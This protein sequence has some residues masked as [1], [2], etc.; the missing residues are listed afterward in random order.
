ME[1]ITLWFSFLLLFSTAIGAQTSGPI[2]P[3]NTGNAFPH[4]HS[5]SFGIARSLS[6]GDAHSLSSGGTSLRLE[7][8]VLLPLTLKNNVALLIPLGCWVGLEHPVLESYSSIASVLPE[9]GIRLRHEVSKWFALGTGI[10]LGAQVFQL[11]RYINSDY[12]AVAAVDTNMR[13]EAEIVFCNVP[14]RPTRPT[15]GISITPSYGVY[16]EQ[17][18]VGQ[19]F[20]LSILSRFS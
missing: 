15:I 6:L 1:R 14:R 17:S 4:V 8:E 12:Q 20:S 3:S 5:V 18:K 2:E 9:A 7:T 19:R 16:F 13:L 11:N 10:L